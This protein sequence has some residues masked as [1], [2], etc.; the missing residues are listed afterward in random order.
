MF[1]FFSLLSLSAVAMLSSACS[2]QTAVPMQVMPVLRPVQRVQPLLP[3]NSRS[4][5][6]GLQGEEVELSGIYAAQTG[7]AVLMLR[8]GE[9]MGLADTLGRPLNQLPG[10]ENRATVRVRGQL[11]ALNTLR[12]AGSMG[13]AVRQVVRI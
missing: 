13:L 9:Q 3:D 2:T 6:Q 8:N 7:G 10:F 4:A 11:R 5:W 12:A 1:R